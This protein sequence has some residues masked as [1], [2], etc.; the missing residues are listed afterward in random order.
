MTFSSLLDS[1]SCSSMILAGILFLHS[2]QAQY[3]QGMP[4]LIQG[5]LLF[6]HPFVQ[7][8]VSLSRRNEGVTVFQSNWAQKPN[9]VL[10]PSIMIRI[11]VAP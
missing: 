6:L 5:N 4:A 9:V 11:E 8:H 10:F 2:L 7:L 3:L 1:M